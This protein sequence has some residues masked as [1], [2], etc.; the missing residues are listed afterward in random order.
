MLWNTYPEV[1]DNLTLAA[2]YQTLEGIHPN[3]VPWIVWLLEN[4]ASPCA[5]PGNIDLFGHDCIHLLLKQ[6]FTITN[7][8]YVLGFTMGNDLNT[9]WFHLLLFKIAAYALYPSTYR[10]SSTE[11]AIFDQGY[12]AGK[13]TEI[14]NLNQINFI[15][16][17][18]KKIGDI[19][20]E[21]DLKIIDVDLN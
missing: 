9:T 21:M 10:M 5:L 16:L 11:L 6:G 8:A 20:L 19:R 2:A 13:N 17:Q 14:K 12:N 7:E 18:Y 4:P 1:L 15:E 3:Q